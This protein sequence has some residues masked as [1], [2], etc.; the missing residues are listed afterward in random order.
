MP[1]NQAALTGP[2]SLGFAFG[3]FYRD[4]GAGASTLSN[5]NAIRLGAQVLKTW[6]GLS[7]NALTR[8]QINLDV[9]C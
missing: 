4:G 6:G 1:V 2:A 7:D 5:A 3:V 8:G 9:R